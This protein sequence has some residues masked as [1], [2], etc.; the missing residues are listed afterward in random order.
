MAFALTSARILDGETFHDDHAV[1]VDGSRMAPGFLASLVH[2]GDD[3][4]VRGT[5]IDG[6]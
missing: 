1:I 2:L 4:Q 3:L 5:W 6:A